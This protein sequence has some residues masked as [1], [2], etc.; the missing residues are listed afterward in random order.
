[1]VVMEF[2]FVPTRKKKFSRPI[3]LVMQHRL[4]R[5]CFL[6]LDALSLS[7]SL[8]PLSLW[9]HTPWSLTLWSLPGLALVSLPGK[10]G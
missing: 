4:A 8:S 7:L 9:S 10:S 3:P 1:M 5:P 2:G 6:C